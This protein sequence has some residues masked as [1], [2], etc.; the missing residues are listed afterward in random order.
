M[1]RPLEVAPARSAG[2]TSPQLETLQRLW[3]IAGLPP[4]SG[5]GTAVVAIAV[6]SDRTLA[7][8]LSSL[9]LDDAGSVTNAVE[10]LLRWRQRTFR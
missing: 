1:T 4:I 7:E 9:D 10:T 6:A 8:M 2:L 3:H 5:Y